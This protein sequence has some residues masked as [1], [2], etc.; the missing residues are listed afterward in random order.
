MRRQIGALLLV[1]GVLGA[2][3]A[4][5]EAQGRAWAQLVGDRV[6]YSGRIR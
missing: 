6:E 4:G 1:L 5:C 2:A 3:A